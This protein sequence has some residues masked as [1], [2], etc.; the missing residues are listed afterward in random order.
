[1]LLLIFRSIRA[2]ARGSGGPGPPFGEKV[3]QNR[4][5]YTPNFEDILLFCIYLTL[6]NIII[7]KNFHPHFTQHNFIPLLDFLSVHIQNFG[8]KGTNLVIPCLCKHENIKYFI[9]IK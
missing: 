1:M 8:F 4:P 6:F 9:C 5:L 7:L 3:Q 2:V